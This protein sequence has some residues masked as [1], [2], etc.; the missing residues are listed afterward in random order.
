MPFVGQNCLFQRFSIFYHHKR[1]KK[2]KMRKNEEKIQKGVYQHLGATLNAGW[3]LVVSGGKYK[4]CPNFI[5]SNLLSP[6]N[7]LVSYL[8]DFK[9]IYQ[10][11]ACINEII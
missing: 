2:K 4:I 5:D 11:V 1:Q 3:H 6:S 8:I 7:L 10:N 9:G